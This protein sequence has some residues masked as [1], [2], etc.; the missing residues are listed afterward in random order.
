[1]NNT[2]VTWAELMLRLRLKK[3]VKGK[4]RIGTESRMV[5][6]GFDHRAVDPMQA[7]TE[8]DNEIHIYILANGET[9][10]SR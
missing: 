9:L 5:V 7:F 10:M 4:A 8:L 2:T 1:M 6:P 3:E